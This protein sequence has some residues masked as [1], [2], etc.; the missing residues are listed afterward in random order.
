MSF[1]NE[2]PMMEDLSGI[3]EVSQRE[4]ILVVEGQFD[5]VQTYGMATCVGL[6]I[7]DKDKNQTLLAHI[8]AATNLERELP[9]AIRSLSENST[10]SLVG[11][12]NKLANNISNI[13]TEYG[14][15]INQRIPLVENI[16]VSTIT[17]EIFEYYETRR[18]TP[19]EISS[20]KL[21]RLH[22]GGKRLFRHMDSIGGGDYVQAPQDNSNQFD[23]NSFL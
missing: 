23:F 8:D 22:F 6:V 20:A 21:D 5:F 13:M 12:S 10:V 17:G 4:Y 14:F 1:A 16:S 3:P 11:G 7:F 19:W 2:L 15:S 9:R 18:T